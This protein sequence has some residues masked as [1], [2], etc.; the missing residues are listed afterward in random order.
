MVE[1]VKGEILDVLISDEPS[2]VK[3]KV[4]ASVVKP[5]F[6]SIVLIFATPE[7]N[8]TR[9]PIVSFSFIF[10]LKPI[11]YSIYEL[12]LRPIPSKEALSPSNLFPLPS[13]L[14]SSRSLG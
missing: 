1:S 13:K 5:S 4:L 14:S 9:P 10:L 11:P 8:L 12:K 7:I 6:V 2:I 3:A